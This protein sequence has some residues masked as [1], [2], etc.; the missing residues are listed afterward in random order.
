[1]KQIHAIALATLFFL[2]TSPLISEEQKKITAPLS[3]GE[4][5]DKITILE[6]KTER[7]T[8]DQ[9]KHNAAFELIPVSI[10]KESA[11]IQVT[12]IQ[13]Q[14][15]LKAEEDTLILQNK[16]FVNRKVHF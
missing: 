15:I 9:K 2:H 6:I 12:I 3:A 16:K 13:I 8:D 11:E 1:M 7:I 10:K 5:M 14:L 4:L